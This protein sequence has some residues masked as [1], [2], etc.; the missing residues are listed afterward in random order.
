VAAVSAPPAA[1]DT[2]AEEAPAH[3]RSTCA[4]STPSVPSTSTSGRTAAIRTPDQLSRPIGRQMP[5]VATSMP[6]SQP[7]LLAVLRSAL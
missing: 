3:S 2:S 5:L 4:L 7:K 6:Q 1:T